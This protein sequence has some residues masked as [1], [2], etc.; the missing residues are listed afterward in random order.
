MVAVRT[1]NILNILYPSDNQRFIRLKVSV[2]ECVIGWAVVLDTRMFNHKQFGNMRVGSIIDCLALP[3]NATIVVSS[4][5]EYLKNAGVDLIVS[6]QSHE[7]WCAGLRESGFMKGPSNFIFSASKK[8]TTKLKPIE[9][10]KSKIHMNRG[11]CDG[12][13]NL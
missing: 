12:P 1:S 6:N 5:T 7:S 9:I 2:N 4:A 10:N 3:E 13:I 11:D 8:L